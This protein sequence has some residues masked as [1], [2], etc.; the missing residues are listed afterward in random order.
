MQNII[1]NLLS[2]KTKSK[3][4]SFK[5]YR[6]FYN[7]THSEQL[8]ATDKRLDICAAEV[9]SY[10]L[11]AGKER[12][13]LRDKVCLEIGSGWLL[14]HS[15]VFYLLGV[16]KI[17]ATDVYPLIQFDYISKAI[18]GSVKC[19]ILDSLSMFEDREIINARCEKLLSF[20]KISP[21]VLQE[22]NI[23]YFAPIDLVQKMPNSEKID[24]IFSKS[25]LEHVPI[26]DIV[27]L[28]K[29]LVSNLS[30][31]G[32]MFHL[33]H[34]L[35]HKDLADRPFDFFGY[36]Q[37]EYPKDLQTRWG[38]RLRSSRWQ[39]IFADLPNLKSK[40]VLEWSCKDRDL[41]A[42]IDQSIQY[43]NEE[44]LRVSHIGILANFQASSS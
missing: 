7:K 25:V 40:V 3:I 1:K 38:N 29:N 4:K 15:L 37:N 22:L 11:Q 9:A 41:P 35:D 20:Q 17:Y 23:N 33:I 5:L 16:I 39:Q 21:E 18:N 43:T 31:T 28:L 26:D 36:S 19:S 24:F 10:L 8:A 27:P 2:E 14:T 32:F 42:K 44:D 13:V 12:Y 6:N 30:P 34:L